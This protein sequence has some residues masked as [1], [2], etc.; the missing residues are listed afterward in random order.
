MRWL[1]L[2]VGLLCASTLLLAWV[3]LRDR[4]ASS[5]RPPEGQLARADARTAFAV[6]GG[7]R[8]RPGC[9][10]QVIGQI[11]PQRWLVR[12]TLRGRPQ[13]LRIDIDTFATGPRGLSGIQPSRCRLAIAASH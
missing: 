6:L 1:G 2:T 7:V 9:R 11:R 13:C 4:D 8:C 10:A 5:W 3:Y 12:L